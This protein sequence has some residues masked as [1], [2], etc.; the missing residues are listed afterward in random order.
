MKAN[1]AIVITDREQIKE[2]PPEEYDLYQRVKLYSVMAVPVT[3]R[4]C[5]FLAI[6]NPK[7]YVDPIYADML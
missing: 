3:P 2:E 5:G 1:Q 7:R 6:R 4:P